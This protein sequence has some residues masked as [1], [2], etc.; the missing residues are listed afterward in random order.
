MI[1]SLWA[2]YIEELRDTRFIEYEWGFISW[3]LMEECIYLEDIY[4]VPEKRREGLA[5]RLVE[6]AE[7]IG[8][9]AGKAFS[10]AVIRLENKGHTESLKA[11]LAAGFVPFLTENGKIWL[12]RKIEPKKEQA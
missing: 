9:K 12:K 8:R 1:P 7:E 10:M 5:L 2:R 4:I 11:H 6:E 3:S